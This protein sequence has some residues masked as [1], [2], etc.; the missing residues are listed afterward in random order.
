MIARPARLS[1]FVLLALLASLHFTADAAAASS[2]TQRKARAHFQAGEERFK[3]GAFADALAAYQAGYDVLPLPGF[4]I[5]VAQ[6]Q[7]R[8]GDLK[9]ARATYQKFVLVAPDSPLVPQVKSMIA[10]IDGLLA[11]L[12]KNKPAPASGETAKA[13]DPPKAAAAEKAVDDGPAPAPVP[14]V[15]PAAPEAA[16]PVLVA[17]PSTEEQPAERPRRRF[18]L[19]AALG[20]VV[21]GGAVTAVVLSTG[22]TTTIHDGSLATLRR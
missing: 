3:A 15:T 18:W 17:A 19:W 4:L 5:N 7:R 10:E 11:E 12:D 21:V 16:A 8:L 14:T 20:A 13:A 9:T 22:G 6:C 2:E 1:P